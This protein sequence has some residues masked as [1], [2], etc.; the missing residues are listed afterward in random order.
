VVY[1]TVHGRGVD[2]AAVV[3]GA[4]FIVYILITDPLF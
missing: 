1:A 4:W 3:A 2:G